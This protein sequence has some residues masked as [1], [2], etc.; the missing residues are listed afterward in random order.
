MYGNVLEWCQDWFD[1]Y[2]PELVV[3]PRGPP[4]GQYLEYRVLRGG[5]WNGYPMDCRS[6]NRGLSRPDERYDYVGFRVVVGVAQESKR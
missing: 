1:T 2:K 3:D 6:A 5:S 4:D